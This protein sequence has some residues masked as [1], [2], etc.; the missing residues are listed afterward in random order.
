LK[1]Q[2]KIDQTPNLVRKPTYVRLH[3]NML[4]DFKRRIMVAQVA[5]PAADLVTL[6]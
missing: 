3:Q 6:S 4:D 5:H 2:E 1:L